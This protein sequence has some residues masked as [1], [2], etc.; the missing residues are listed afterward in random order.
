MI[1]R[2]LSQIIER[3]GI[4]CT[5]AQLREIR[6]LMAEYALEAVSDPEIRQ[7]AESITKLTA[8]E[9]KPMEELKAFQKEVYKCAEDHGFWEVKN[10]H[11]PGNQI[12]MMHA[13]L[14]E[15]HEAI[16][17]KDPQDEHIPEFKAVEAELADVILRVLQ[18]SEAYGY[19]TIDAMVAKH[20][21]N[22][23]RPFKHGGKKY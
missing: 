4:G 2:F 7:E 10:E 14:S 5:G 11:T 15:A 21:Y 9:G 12:C 23:K 18:F 22:L 13:E 16:R 3:L 17:G 19:R 20:A 6:Q 1:E 8:K